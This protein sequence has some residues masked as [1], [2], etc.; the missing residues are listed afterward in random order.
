MIR[1]HEGKFCAVILDPLAYVRGSPVIFRREIQQ[2]GSRLHC[3]Y[4]LRH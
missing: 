3:G 2:E 1:D 4:N